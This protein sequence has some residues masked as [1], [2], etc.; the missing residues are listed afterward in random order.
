MT[1]YFTILTKVKFLS[2]KRIDKILLHNYNDATSTYAPWRVLK[3]N[4]TVCDIHDSVL[5]MWVC[6]CVSVCMCMILYSNIRLLRL[7]KIIGFYD[8]WNEPPIIYTL[9]DFCVFG[10]ERQWS[11]VITIYILFNLLP[12]FI[13]TN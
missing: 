3:Y 7:H 10:A 9:W 5:C 1:I 4:I 13:I 12:C 2:T 8:A 6:M 11:S